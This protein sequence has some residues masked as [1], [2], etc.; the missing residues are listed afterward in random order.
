MMRATINPPDEI[1]EVVR[2]VA[3]AKRVSM[4]DA[5][6][7]LIKGGLS[8]EFRI[9]ETSPFPHFAP[10]KGAPP[11]TLGATLEAEDAR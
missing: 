1:Y 10:R 2:S 5:I 11:S 3:A 9:G 8:P 4:S 7:E 6:T